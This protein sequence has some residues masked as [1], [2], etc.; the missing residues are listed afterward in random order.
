MYF[1]PKIQAIIHAHRYASNTLYEG[2]PVNRDSGK[3]ETRKKNPI[4]GNETENRNSWT[5]GTHL[6]AALRVPATPH[7]VPQGPGSGC[8]TVKAELGEF[9]R[10]CLWC[11]RRTGEGRRYRREVT[12]KEEEVEEEEG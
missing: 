3:T 11:W 2:A 8:Q 12:G 7:T 1:L 5:L 9:S 10:T 6:L 4:T